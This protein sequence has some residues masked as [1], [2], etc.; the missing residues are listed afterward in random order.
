MNPTNRRTFIQSLGVATAGLGLASALPSSLRAEENQTPHH[1]LSDDDAQILQTGDEIAVAET[2]H[3]KVRGFVLNGITTFRGIPYGADTSGPNRFLPPKKPTPWTEV[4]PALWWGPSAPQVMAGRYSR[5]EA[6]FIDHWNYYDLSEDCLKLNVWTPALDGSKRP[7][8]LWLHGG[9]F[10]EGNC[11]EQDGYH[12]ENFSRLGNVVYC[13]LNHR[14]GPM[15]FSNFAAALGE[16]YASSGNVGMLDIVLGLEWIRDNIKN[17]GGDPGNVTIIGQSGGGAKVCTLMAMPAAKGLFHKAVSLSG[18]SL[19][20]LK[21]EYSEKLGHYILAEANLTASEVEKLRQIPWEEYLTLAQR[22]AKRLNQES[23]G[24]A[25]RRSGFAPTSDGEVLPIEPY[26]S[27]PN[28]L[29]SDIPLIVCSTFNESSPSRE[30]SSLENVTLD[31]VKEKLH[32]RFGDKTEEVVD[33]YNR[34]FPGKKPVEI[35]SLVASNRQAPVAAANAKSNQSAP[36]YV[37]WFGFQPPLF[38][39]RMRAFH[40]LDISFWFANTDRMWTHSG[41]GARPRRLSDKMAHSLVQFMRTGNPNGGGLPDWP[42]YTA[43]KGETMI[44]NDTCEV[45]N[46][47]DREARKTLTA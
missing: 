32:S 28:G 39:H 22:A 16:Q 27:D 33:A 19:G 24:S 23:P 3:G 13:S 12:G 15:G 43:A 17:F 4:R 20:G 34:V 42:V 44:L 10:T 36:V 5:N 47:P 11:I 45:R 31:Q 1:T 9:G 40:T 21:K 18:S 26:F 30:D 6:S 46:D 2:E 38:D 8:I 7:V 35:W 37:A 41:G 29:S 25:G 14:L